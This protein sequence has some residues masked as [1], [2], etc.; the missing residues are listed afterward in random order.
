VA[1][2][3]CDGIVDLLDYAIWGQ[4][5]GETAG[6]AA[7]IGDINGDGIVDIRDYGIWRANFGHTAAGTPPVAA[8]EGP[9]LGAVPI[10]GEPRLSLA[11]QAAPTEASAKSSPDPE[12][13]PRQLLSHFGPVRPWE[14]AAAWRAAFPHGIMLQ[15]TE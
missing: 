3:N 4:H 9:L 2:L 5:F 1:D 15:R 8:L 10:P 7:P 12:A 6:A 13:W 14:I 11:R